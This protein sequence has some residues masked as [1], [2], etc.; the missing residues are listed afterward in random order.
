MPR[1]LSPRDLFLAVVIPTD[2]LH[3]KTGTL[4]A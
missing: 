2:E 3:S 1:R 4:T